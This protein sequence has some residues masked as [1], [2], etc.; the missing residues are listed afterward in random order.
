MWLPNPKNLCEITWKSMVAHRFPCGFLYGTMVFPPGF[1]A[2]E[3]TSLRFLNFPERGNL[4]NLEVV[5][6]FRSVSEYG[7]FKT[8]IGF[9]F[10]KHRNWR[11]VVSMGFP[12]KRNIH[13]FLVSTYCETTR[14]CS[15]ICLCVKKYFKVKIF[16]TQYVLMSWVW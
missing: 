7:I 13:L 8:S 16:L 3:T 9:Y 10:G 4:K 11:I 12:L 5:Q 1:R 6:S 2:E 14:N 15:S